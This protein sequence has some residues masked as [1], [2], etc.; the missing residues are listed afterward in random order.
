MLFLN[1]EAMIDISEIDRGR[2]RPQT[3]RA[4]PFGFLSKEITLFGKGMSDRK[5]ERFYTELHTLLTAGVDI[6]T[7]FELLVTEAE[8][9]EDK[10]LYESILH[11]IVAGATLPDAV[12]ATD[13]FTPYEYYSLRI[14]EEAGRMN[15]VLH[16]LSVY[17]SKKIKQKRKV[18][19]ALSY[20]AIVITVAV[21]AVVFMLRFVVPMF[22]DMLSRFGSDLPALTK[23]V[24][25]ASGFLGRYGLWILAV[26]TGI[27]FFMY[28]RRRK[29]RFRRLVSRIVLKL[30]FIG[31]ITR[32]VY[33]ERFAHAMHLLLLSKTN[34]I[35]A[36]ELV[37]KMVAFYPIEQSLT[38]IRAEV[39]AGA[40]L[41]ESMAKHAIY[42]KRMISLIRVAEE[43]NQ[44]DTMFG[45]LSHQLSDEIDHET[46]MLG[47][48]IE[49]L[50]ILCL[51]V[52]V[53]VILV[54]MY[55]PMFKLGTAFG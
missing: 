40:S 17:Y 19:G 45:K 22:A 1:S 43:V 25:R 51:G 31:K 26:L 6:R 50:M 10:A 14:G 52:M 55:L 13:K 4:S 28:S 44:L 37:Q 53:A 29:E 42:P 30:P 20:P 33:V 48:V 3:E 11:G 16:D 54:A 47:S 5:K 27:I 46:S 2:T 39:F 41:Y 38:S 24:I 9:K 49:P 18:T 23:L 34:L 21:L 35:D 15:N 12:R 7:A 32:K 36:L 8:R